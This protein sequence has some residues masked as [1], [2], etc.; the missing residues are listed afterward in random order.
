MSLTQRQ[1]DML[2]IIR[3]RLEHSEVGPNYDEIAAEMGIVK[4]GVHR[5]AVALKERGYI[6]FMP[7]RARSIRL[8]NRPE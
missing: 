3:R 4:S 5:M 6:T 8:L 7:G 1:A 2:D